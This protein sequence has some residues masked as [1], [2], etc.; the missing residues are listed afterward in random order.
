MTATP[1][2]FLPQ[3]ARRPRRLTTPHT[4]PSLHYFGNQSRRNHH[5]GRPQK[6]P[7]AL[8]TFDLLNPE[9][10]LLL[11]HVPRVDQA[12][13]FVATTP[14]RFTSLRILATWGLTNGTHAVMIDCVH[15]AKHFI[16]AL[17]CVARFGR[18]HASGCLAKMTWLANEVLWL[19]DRRRDEVPSSR[20][21]VGSTDWREARELG[22]A[23]QV[24]PIHS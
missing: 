12:P 24:R 6:Q 9:D 1:D 21:T 8:P 16:V 14:H 11:T 17:L 15:G 7:L 22:T 23:G 3:E 5:A 20:D 4:Q 18:C 19:L 10:R 2:R 13:E